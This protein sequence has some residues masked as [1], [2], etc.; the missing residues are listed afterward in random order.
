M[1]HKRKHDISDDKRYRAELQ[2]AQVQ[3]SRLQRHVIANNLKILVIFEGR[4][5]AGKDG[6]IKRIT[7]HLSPR[8]TRVVALDPPSDRERRSWYFQRYV[9]HLPASGE[10]ALFNRSWYNR[11]GVEQVMG[12][13]SE[14][15]YEEFLV[16]A[17]LFENLLDHCGVRLIKYY[18]DISKKEQKARI[19]SRTKDPLRQW[20]E[21]KVDLA[22]VKRWADYTA[23]RDT[24]LAR[25]HTLTAPWTIVSANDKRAARIAVMRDLIGRFEFDDKASQPADPAILFPFHET[26]ALES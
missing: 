1:G 24:M 8:E 6:V 17:P 18:L 26:A 9:A 5:A 13:C 23:L 2:E 22:A 15:E 21:S 4:D 12:F 3:L 20:K 7:R 11:A 14:A 16:T 19:E 25:T 10:I